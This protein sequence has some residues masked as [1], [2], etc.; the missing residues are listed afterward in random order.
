M[1]MEEDTSSEAASC[2]VSP[3]SCLHLALQMRCEAQGQPSALGQLPGAK[4]SAPSQGNL[5]GQ[6]ACSPLARSCPVAV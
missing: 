4:P 6:P 5:D 3:S 2:Q 1:E